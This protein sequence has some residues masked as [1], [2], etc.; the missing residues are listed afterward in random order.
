MGFP[1]RWEKALEE[2]RSKKDRLKKKPAMAGKDSIRY[3]REVAVLMAE[4]RKN[5][6][7][8][9]TEREAACLSAHHRNPRQKSFGI[10]R[11]IAEQRV[12]PVRLQKELDKCTC[13]CFNCHAKLEA[14]KLQIAHTQPEGGEPG[15]AGEPPPPIFLDRRRFHR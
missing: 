2:R 1:V 10:S 9:C 12:S 7:A 15:Q 8:A 11:A 13:L 5:G 3:R 14:G 6:C 4:F